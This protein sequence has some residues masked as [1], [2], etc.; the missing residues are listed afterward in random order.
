M[1][2]EGIIDRPPFYSLFLLP[3]HLGHFL[4]PIPFVQNII[5][6][7]IMYRAFSIALPVFGPRRMAASI[8][9]AC[10]VT[11]LLWYSNQIMPDIFTP[12]IVL[13]LFC[14]V[15]GWRKL[16]RFEHVAMPAALLAMM[17]F[18]TSNPLFSVAVTA[19]AVALA[20]LRG[21]PARQV[22]RRGALVAGLALLAVCGQT[23]Y[24]YAVIGR[25]TP[26]PAAPFFTLA[27]LIYDGPARQYLAK[28]CPAAGYFLCDY[29]QDFR[30]NSDWFLWQPD[31]P[32]QKLRSAK[33]E[34]GALSEAAAIVAGT[35]RR[36]PG[37]VAADAAQNAARQFMSVATVI[38]DCPCLGGKIGRVI[39]ELF[40]AEAAQYKASLQNRGLIPWHVLS[41]IDW[42]ALGASVAALAVILVSAPAWLQGGAGQLLALISFALVINATLMGA[43]SSVTDRYQARL[44]WLIPLF[45]IVLIAH[46]LK[47][48]E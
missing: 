41:W 13:L 28:A 27:R 5:A 32:L 2:L 44:I 17:S 6:V 21:D 24:G 46:R 23:L 36:Y 30:G 18:H 48:A 1:R 3:L 4:W 22:L 37:V 31:S 38:T 16:T 10:L 42:L 12:L 40:P 15:L 11:S 29:Q 43:L 47:P 39:P 33:S 8:A 9:A 20:L 26:A 25:V 35:L 34:T 19:A 7:T 14:I 45:A